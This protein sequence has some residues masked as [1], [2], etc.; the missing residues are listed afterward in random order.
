MVH[1]QDP[2]SR[3]VSAMEMSRQEPCLDGSKVLSKAERTQAKIVVSQ[4]GAWGEGA[5]LEPKA[6]Y[7]RRNEGQ[8]GWQDCVRMSS[9]SNLSSRGG[10]E[11]QGNRRRSKEAKECSIMQSQGQ[12]SGC[13]RVGDTGRDLSF[14]AFL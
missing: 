13:V 9:P 5:C 14:Q 7:Q 1:I 8:K 2:P 3:V 6:S 11:E 10:S 4:L 12:P